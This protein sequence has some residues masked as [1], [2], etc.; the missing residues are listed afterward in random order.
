MKLKPLNDKILFKFMDDIKHGFFT[1]KHDSGIIIDLGQNHKHSSEVSRL[2]QVVA[3]GPKVVN[4]D[5]GDIVV[6][7]ALKWTTKYP[8]SSKMVVWMTEQQYVL[9]IVGRV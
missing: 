3:I 4:I 7:E 1:E 6:V 8:V 2:C 5:V 9:G